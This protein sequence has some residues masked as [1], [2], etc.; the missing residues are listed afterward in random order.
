MEINNSY[1][2]IPQ[3]AI[4]P[5]R[6]TSYSTIEWHVP[7]PYRGKKH[8]ITKE[9]KDHNGKVSVNARRKIGKAIEYLLFLAREKELPDT[10]NGRNYKF[11]LAFITLTLPSTQVH[12]DNEIKSRCLNQFLIEARAKWRVQNYLWRAEKQKNGNLHFHILVD[13]FCPWSEV[14]DV[15]NRITNKLGYVDRYRDE[16][17]R[18]HAGGFK[19]R[20]DLLKHWDYKN[21][22]KSYNAAKVNDWASPNSTDIHSVHK[23]KDIKSYVSKYCTKDEQSAGLKGRMWGCNEKLSDIK[24]AQIIVDG[25][26]SDEVNELIDKFGNRVYEGDY[27][28][29]IDIEFKQLSQL[30]T[31]ELFK[32]FAEYLNKHFGTNYQ[33]QIYI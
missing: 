19:V 7:K 13:K 8:D 21:Q 12:S 9:K 10:Y 30:S 1:S 6:I 27:F 32:S 33:S 4:H 31:K 23:V 5:N 28:A 24:G 17:R 29:V 14:R 3:I 2:V 26:V 22:L 20:E 18:F 25:S 11:K 15:W 16:M